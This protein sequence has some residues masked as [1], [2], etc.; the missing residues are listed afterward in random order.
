MENKKEIKFTDYNK[1]CP[2]YIEE[3]GQCLLQVTYNWNVNDPR[4]GSCAEGVCPVFYWLKKGE[5]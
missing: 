5:K 3:T 1:D 2:C 4:Y